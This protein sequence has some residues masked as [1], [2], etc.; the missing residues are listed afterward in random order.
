MALIGAVLTKMALIK[1]VFY[2]KAQIY[3]EPFYL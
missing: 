1:A 2:Q 3:L